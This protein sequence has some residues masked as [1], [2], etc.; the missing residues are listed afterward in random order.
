M[1][2]TVPAERVRQ[3]NSRQVRGDGQ[4]V[5]YWMI[6][7][8][9]PGW[10]FSLD[11]AVAWATK[12][13]KPLVVFEALRCGYRWAS[14][15]LHRFIIDGMRD[16]A[17]AFADKP[18]FYYPYVE[19]TLDAGKG[20][21][22]ALAENACAVVTDDFPTFFL[23]AMVKAVARRLPVPL[24]AV[25]SNGLYPMYATDQ[26]FPT[27]YA[28]RRHL[29]KN[30]PAYLQEMPAADPLKNIILPRL[31]QLPGDIATRWPAAS[32]ALLQGDAGELAK[33]PIDHSVAIAPSDG[34]HTAAK[35]ALDGFIKHKLA[36]YHED[37]ND[38]ERECTTGLSP[39]LHFGH[40]SAHEVFSALTRH[41]QWSPNKLSSKASGA[42]EGW[43]GASPSAEA[44][45]DQLVTWR[46]LGYNFCSHRD[47]YDQFDSLP[48]WAQKTLDK[49]AAD[50]RPHVYER[51]E[52]EHART[53]DPLWNAAQR[54]IVREGRM[55][56]YLRMLWGKKILE[57]SVTPRDALATMIE[58][59]NK[60]GL[61][62]RNPN[63][64]SGIFWTLG[65]YDRPWGPERPIFGTIRYMTSDNTARKYNV[66][67][68]LEKYGEQGT[69]FS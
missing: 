56:N 12:L 27:A 35:K 59:N 10:N 39:Y 54:Q 26:V 65:R 55:H 20:L 42:R 9:R 22:E 6:A 25:D 47:D 33:L 45:L 17:A 40:I 7:N 48:D 13:K 57:W 29:Q 15:R 52:F 24:S 30:L 43:W 37:R 36:D 16:N 4:Y 14:D 8:R 49:H 61:D 58:L 21:L 31:V 67:P 51:E 41:E 2:P 60:Y 69:L 3:L 53:H 11:V 64:Y 44:L 66:K 23:P 5:L 19:P 63:S 34:G 32:Q 46:E 68:Y 28:F 1:F 62:G 50:P 18:V 38:M